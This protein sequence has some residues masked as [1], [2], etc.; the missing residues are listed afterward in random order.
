MKKAGLRLSIQKTKV[1]VF[2]P[3]TSWKIGGGKMEM[4]ADFVWGGSKIT[5]DGDYSPEIKRRLLLGRKVITKIEARSPTL[6]AD[7]LSAEPQGKPNNT[8]VGSLSL[9]QQIFPTQ[10]SN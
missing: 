5:A 9:L 2:S 3:I 6:Q 8:G 1:T 7:S 4:V 10:E